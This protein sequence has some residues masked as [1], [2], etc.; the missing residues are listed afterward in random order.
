MSASAERARL[1]WQGS[2]SDHSPPIPSLRPCL[3]TLWRPRCAC[4]WPF[5]FRS[6]RATRNATAWNTT[7]HVCGARAASRAAL[8]MAW[9]RCRPPQGLQRRVCAGRGRLLACARPVL[10]AAG[11]EGCADG[12][13][14]AD[15]QV[16]ALP[17]AIGS[18]GLVQRRRSP[19]GA[20]PSVALVQR[21]RLWPGARPSVSS[22]QLVRPVCVPC[23]VQRA[24]TPPL[25]TT[26]HLLRTT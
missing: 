13:A 17:S 9:M 6:V 2:P 15:A 26:C 5:A 3:A 16:G 20:T 19:P 21:R 24:R 22:V 11:R 23:A 1:R 8:A 18:G 4:T 12:R 7:R 25:C 10:C 14:H